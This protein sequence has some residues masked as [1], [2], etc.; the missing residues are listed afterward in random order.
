M[1]AA[2][3]QI[4]DEALRLHERERARVALRLIESLETA[5]PDEDRDAA[6][7]EELAARN[8][9]IDSGGVRALTLDE[10]MAI[11]LADG[12]DEPAR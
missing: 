4:L 5:A 8:R 7:S 6:W 1:S 9:E 10:T 3:K 12:D 2:E 11:V